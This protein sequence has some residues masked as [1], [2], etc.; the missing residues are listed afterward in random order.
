MSSEMSASVRRVEAADAESISL[1]DARPSLTPVIAIPARNEEMFLPRLIE[2]LARQTVHKEPSARPLDVVLVINNTMDKSRDAVAAAA[3]RVPELRVIVEEVWYLPEHAHVGSARRRAADIAASLQPAGA[4]LTT[5]ADA[6]PADDWIEANLKAL[7][8]GADLV[9]GQIFGDPEE[10]AR[11][12]AGFLRR[13]GLHAR[14]TAR[15]DELAALLDPI[16]HDPWPRHQDHT[17]ASLAVRSTVYEAVGGLDA[18]PFREDL[19]FVSK[20]RAAGFRLTHPLDVKVTVSARTAGRA[21]GGMADCVATWVREDAAG[22]PVRVECPIAIET[23]LR[24]RRSL[25]ALGPFGGEGG[26]GASLLSPEGLIERFAANDPD[27]PA[28]VD[29]ELAI[30]RI[31]ARIA[32]ARRLSDVG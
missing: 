22:H 6:V 18:L 31:E 24:R 5:D 10:E 11:L 23:R 12:G 15:C 20:V 17:G 32:E 26:A 9:G 25:R 19:A 27:A 3:E 4:I 16:A 21:P 1:P 14:Y 30:A 2:A 13:A 28:T 7:E 29:A 8:A